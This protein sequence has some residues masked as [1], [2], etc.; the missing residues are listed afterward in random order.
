M[1]SNHPSSFIK[2]LMSVFLLASCVEDIDMNT[3]EELPL[4]V[5]CVLKM[6]TVQTLRL[7]HMK[8]LNADGYEP[9]TEARVELQLI[10]KNGNLFHVAEFHRSEGLLWETRFKPGFG[11]SYRLSVTL[12]GKEEVSATTTFPEDM[13]L[14]LHEKALHDGTRLYDNARDTTV[15]TMITAE[16]ATARMVTMD[17]F[18]RGVLKGVP[19]P[20]DADFPVKAYIPTG[21]KACKMWLYPRRDSIV[22][23]PPDNS[24]EWAPPFTF[25]DLPFIQ[26]PKPYCDFVVT[27]HPCADNF[28]V[29]PG[30]V[31]DL[32]LVNVPV[33][34]MTKVDK[35]YRF[36]DGHYYPVYIDSYLLNYTQ[37]IPQMC[38]DL[39]LHKGF[40]RIDQPEGFTNGLTDEDLK[41][42][43]QSSTNS[44][45]ILGDYSDYL[46]GVEPFL[47]EVRFLSDEYDAFLR[48]LHIRNLS[49][50]NFIL[51]TYDS[52]N[53]YSN[54]TGGVGVF[55]AENTTWAEEACH[56][57]F[58]YSRILF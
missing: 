57:T 51:S 41:T 58:P 32:D 50:D 40:V 1:I 46:I 37:W 25:S 17:D 8:R 53:I 9:V 54:I 12:P 19:F 10:Q 38:P 5:D 23:Y 26:S 28:N 31:T 24:T 27:D 47:I 22:V 39:P 34:T 43:Y 45:L 55:G 11:E 4:V 48:D 33:N 44:F 49:R 6:D 56:K 16:I 35:K 30:R 3:G 2:V 52:N 14:V 13:R 36:Y 18:N 29:V 7:Y 20:E 42:S 15:L 21:N